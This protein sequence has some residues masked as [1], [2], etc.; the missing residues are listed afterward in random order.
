MF[1]NEFDC[2]KLWQVVFFLLRTQPRILLPV[3]AV[4]WPPTFVCADNDWLIVARFDT[5]FFWLT[6]P[7][8]YLL[9][10]CHLA[11]VRYLKGRTG[12]PP[13]PTIFVK[14][15]KIL[16]SQLI[17]ITL[18]RPCRDK[19]LIGIIWEKNIKMY[20]FYCW[21]GK[22]WDGWIMVFNATF[23]NITIVLWRSVLLVGTKIGSTVVLIFYCRLHRHLQTSFEGHWLL[24]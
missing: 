16:H 8:G 3:L 18:N 7:A 13:P 11:Y 12:L 20:C 17:W 9:T 19:F 24:L 1:Q 10:Y 5:N 22:C 15:N 14:W 6:N 23:N 2:E 4:I 21:I